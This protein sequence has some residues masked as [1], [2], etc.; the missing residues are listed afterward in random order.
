MN[1]YQI[2]RIAFLIGEPARAAMLLELMDG[3][4]LTANELASAAS[5]TPQTASRHLAQMVEGGLMCVEQRGRHRYHRLASVDVAKTLEG[6]MQM[7]CASAT[8]RRSVTPG[9]KDEA[10]RRARVCYDHIA[11]RLGLA[12]ADHLQAEGAIEFDGEHGTVTPLAESV[13]TR[14]GLTLD[15][16][17]SS[18]SRSRPYCRPCLDWSERKPHV[19]GRLG[20]LLCSHCLDQGWLMRKAGGR[21]L[22]VTVSGA[23]ALRDLLGLQ[24][25]ERVSEAAL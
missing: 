1:T 12:I 6:L 10:M 21:A 2:A 15:H 24:A 22:T 11:G 19:A 16:E 25:W 20:A 18:S 9:P 17:P 8:P 13:M 7:A 3:R 23:V 4:S 14:W 5:V